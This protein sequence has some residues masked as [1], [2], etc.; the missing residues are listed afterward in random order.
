MRQCPRCKTENKDTSVFCKECGANILVEI[1][2]E[3]LQRLLAEK[4]E[5]AEQ[6]RKE[7]CSEVK[8]YKEE[9]KKESEILTLEEQRQS[10][11][12][13]IREEKDRKLQSE[14]TDLLKKEKEQKKELEVLRET[15]DK[16]KKEKI[17]MEKECQKAREYLEIK[18]LR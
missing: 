17:D 1:E 7:L 6:E 15:I 2:I 3:E 10:I 16:V 14:L 9:Q 8:R 11:M 12:Q 18:G 13:E 5:N 4:A